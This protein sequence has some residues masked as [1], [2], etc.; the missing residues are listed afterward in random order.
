MAASDLIGYNETFRF[1]KHQ[2]NPQ[3]LQNVSQKTIYVVF[4]IKPVK[5]KLSPIENWA[6]ALF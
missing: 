4:V 5:K 3:S 6:I 2:N 1:S